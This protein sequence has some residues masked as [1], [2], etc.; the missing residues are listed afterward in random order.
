MVLILGS[1]IE[2]LTVLP[3]KVFDNTLKQNLIK[4]T[5]ELLFVSWDIKTLLDELWLE[6]ESTQRKSIINQWLE[7]KSEET[8]SW[9]IP[10]WYE[11]YPEIHWQ[12]PLQGHTI[13]NG[14]IADKLKDELINYDE[15]CPLPPFTWDNERREQ[16]RAELDAYFALLY[17]LERKQIRYI[18]D[19]ADLTEGELKDIL[20]PA[21]EIDNVLNEEAYQKRTEVSTFPGETFRVLKNKELKKHGEYRTRRLVLEAYNRLRPDWDMET[22]RK[23]LKQVWEEYQVDKSEEKPEN[24]KQ[25]AKKNKKTKSSKNKSTN[26]NIIDLDLDELLKGI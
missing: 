15:G 21:E 8:V 23:K 19:P 5:L 11:A 20:D 18:L 9:E 4:L 12:S 10:D 25:G 6:A 14:Q 3:T 17:G 16:L 2:Q 13:E 22:H 1:I 7:N 26:Q 24:D